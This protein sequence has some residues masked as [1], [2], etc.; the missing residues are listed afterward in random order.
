MEALRSLTG[1]AILCVAVITAQAQSLAAINQLWRQTVAA[2]QRGDD[3]QARTEFTAFNTAV[4]SY[5][6]ANGKSWQIE[7]LVGSLD[8]LF[9]DKKSSWRGVSAR[10]PTK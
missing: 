10:H 9:P 7:Y 6:S 4:R 8:C 1:I 3:S 5:V 2:V